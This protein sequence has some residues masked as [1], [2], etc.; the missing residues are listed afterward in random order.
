MTEFICDQSSLQGGV[1]EVRRAGDHRLHDFDRDVFWR[2]RR[3][4]APGHHLLRQN[5]LRCGAHPG[6]VRLVSSVTLH[7]SH[8]VSR[9]LHHW[10]WLLGEEE[11]ATQFTYEITAFKGNT[12]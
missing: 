2:R 7:T 5:L 8:V 6:Q 3:L 9:W 11:E 1:S 4:V 12:K 10:V